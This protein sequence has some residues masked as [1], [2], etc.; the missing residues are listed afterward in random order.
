M[1]Q[2]TG[3]LNLLGLRGLHPDLYRLLPHVRMPRAQPDGAGRL[4]A[5]D[6]NRA[7]AAHQR[8]R[9]LTDNFAGKVWQTL[10]GFIPSGQYTLNF[11]LGSRYT[12]GAY[13]GNQAMWT[14]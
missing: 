1:F 6:P 11:Y 12:S 4:F 13:D 7:N 14:E 2:R 10:G 5:S 8:K 9:V 3:A